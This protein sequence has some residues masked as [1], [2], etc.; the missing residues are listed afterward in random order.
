VS[1]LTLLERARRIRLLVLDVDGVLTD[2]R[3]YFGPEGEALKAF[4]V[5]DGAGLVALRRAGVGVAII[6][7]RDSPAVTLRARELGIEH[8]RQ[9]IHDKGRAL[10]ELC[11]ALGLRPE[12]CACVGDDTP[13][14]P[15]F[16]RAALAVAVA[17][18]HP[19]LRERAHHVTTLPGGNGAVREVCDL[20][21]RARA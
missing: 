15:L 4:H 1:V 9:G 3:L 11:A 5:R 17:D 18:A 10:E 21:L 19:A 20:L 12:D 8:L 16:E 14:L 2:G 6:S 7:G 13:D